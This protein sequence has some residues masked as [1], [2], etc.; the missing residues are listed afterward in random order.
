MMKTLLSTLVVTTALTSAAMAG[1]PATPMDTGPRAL[2][3]EQMDQVT[4]GGGAAGGAV[5]DAVRS[6]AT[7][8]ATATTRP[9][10]RLARISVQGGRTPS[11]NNPG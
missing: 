3:E 7:T 1:E 4:A 5:N 9:S 10:T 11:T 8:S 2:T 6:V